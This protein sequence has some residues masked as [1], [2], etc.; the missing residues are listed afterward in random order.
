MS[1]DPSICAKEKVVCWAQDKRSYQV[2]E[3]EFE[4][5]F[6][7]N[8]FAYGK[9]NAIE[10]DLRHT[11]NIEDKRSTKNIFTLILRL[12]ASICFFK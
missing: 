7:I 9:N 1:T 2:K 10:F 5:L 8:H 6:A 11:T 12:K 4:K 3:F